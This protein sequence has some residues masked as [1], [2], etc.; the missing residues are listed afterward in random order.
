MKR[1]ITLLIIALA[2]IS[3]AKSQVII[4]GLQSNSALER[5][6]YHAPEKGLQHH[7][8]TPIVLPF[9]DDFSSMKTFPD[10]AKWVSNQV[11]INNDYA[12]RPLTIGV[13]TFDALDGYGKIYSTAQSDAFAAD[14]LISRPIR[15][16]TIFAPL[17]R[18][19][20]LAD[21]I[22][23]SFYY[24]P[25]G[26][27]GQPWAL[28]GDKPETGDSL[29]LDFGFFTGNYIYSYSEYQS[30]IITAYLN[31]G[32]SVQNQCY[33]DQWIVAA[34]IYE[35]NDTLWVPCDSIF[36]REMTWNT[37]WGADGQTLKQLFDSTG[38]YFKQVLLPITNPDYL[39]AGFQF[40]FRNLASMGNNSL[41]GW[42]GN[43]DQWNIDYVK[44]NINRTSSDTLLK[45]VAFA[46]S[47]PTTL[48]HYQTMPWS[49]FK[50]HQ[51]AEL[52]DSLTILLTNLDNITKNT[53]YVYDVNATSGSLVHHY[54]GGSFNIDPYS[55]N[56]YQTYQPHARPPIQFTYPEDSQDSAS[57][58]TTHIFKEAGGA[59]QNNFNDTIRYSQNFFN[60]FS[61][62]DG[63]AENGFGLSPAGSKLAYKF[64]L[65][66]PDT[67][68]AVNMFFN[69]TLDNANL[70]YFWLT[71]W[72]DNNGQ[73]GS[74]IYEQNSMRPVFGD[75]LNQFRTYAFN[76]P[77]ALSG[78]FYI[79]WRQT[80]DDNLNVGFD[81]NHDASSKI[82]YNSDGTWSNTI[83]SG[84]L[85]MRPMLGKSFS[86][87]KIEEQAQ[88]KISIFP[89]PV[90]GKTFS[91]TMDDNFASYRYRITDLA[92]RIV[93][94]QQLETQNGIDLQAGLYII[95]VY[96]MSQS[97]HSQ[98][99]IVY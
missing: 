64:V 34:R 4:S 81:R 30:Q 25:G 3:G 10:T 32:D 26:G 6:Q 97:V 1:Y 21:S 71:V 60:Y 15:L 24:Q 49:Q 67:L 37:V 50:G 92:G 72:N 14:T 77:I 68:R 52:T 27:I 23:F 83:Y 44:L 96:K 2:G 80:T 91:V 33:P 9:E 90:T 56:G 17:K 58:T 62:D 20:T 53:S 28:R 61:Y 35:P 39:N 46:C 82:F 70:Q 78:T 18:A 66:T 94:E 7:E 84:A 31:A 11:F 73:P 59:D 19:I 69:R 88:T 36:I 98:K 86:G 45:D 89:N 54:D 79:G 8:Y 5:L 87:V 57:F 95:T 74:V 43:V 22:Y 93:A 51:A 12:F 38:K 41:P 85:M 65:N 48:K 47:A 13:A 55:S 16:D 29:L 42:L 99:L 40:R 76:Q 75:S 63:T